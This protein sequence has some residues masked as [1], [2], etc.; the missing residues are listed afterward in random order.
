MPNIMVP[1]MEAELAALFHNAR[2]GL[3]LLLILIEMG[4]PQSTTPVQTNNA[5]AAGIT[6][7]T[8]KQCQSN[9]IDMRF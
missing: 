5:C 3:P 4:H 2:D 8:V 1:T 9:A 6:N 7:E